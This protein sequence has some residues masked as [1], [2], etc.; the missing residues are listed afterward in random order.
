MSQH[1]SPPACT[2]QSIAIR[3]AGRFACLLPDNRF[4]RIPDQRFQTRRKPS[5]VRDR[6]LVATFRSS[7]TLAPL[8]ACVTESMLPACYFASWT[9]RFFDPFGPS[10]L[11]PDSGVPRFRPL[12]RLRPV[13]KSSTGLTGCIPASAH[14]RD[15]YL[16]P[17][18]SFCWNRC[19]SV[20]LPNPPDRLS[21]P[22][23]V[24]IARFSCGSSFRARYV[25][26]IG[27]A[28]V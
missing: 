16:P 22:A 3:S 24:S 13:A 26:E 11:L 21:L 6:M 7:A 15:C 28:H 27:R 2:A 17:D 19:L 4:R 14:R 10:A 20:R 1:C 9:C 5:P 23:A 8:E 12:Q 18:Q 25:S